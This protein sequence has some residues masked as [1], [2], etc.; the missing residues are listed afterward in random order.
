MQHSP[1]GVTGAACVVEHDECTEIRLSAKAEL[2]TSLFSTVL[3]LPG[4]LEKGVCESL[5]EAAD[6][7]APSSISQTGTA[8]TSADGT[9]VRVPLANLHNTTAAAAMQKLLHEHILPFFE[10]RPELSE[11]LF[12]LSRGLGAM[13]TTWGNGEPAV[14]R[15]LPG[16]E[17]PEHVDHETLTVLTQLSP[18]GSFTGGGT[19]FWP[20][21]E[22]DANTRGFR[23]PVRTE[24]NQTIVNLPRGEVLLFN[25]E[26]SH[27]G[28]PIQSGVRHVLVGSFNLKLSAAEIDPDEFEA[29]ER[30]AEEQ[31]AAAE[32]EEKLRPASEDPTCNV[33]R[34]R[35]WSWSQLLERQTGRLGHWQSWRSTRRPQAVTLSVS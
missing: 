24:E 22:N 34:A 7:S 26:L 3:V 2:N 25:G 9:R 18:D 29:V 8:G 1:P 12:G 13:R 15:Y 11:S 10:R 35:A 17:F 33:R 5:I 31:A 27:A 4:A 21:E 32:H 30:A 20:E 28:L 14:N 23:P 6:L 19:V 16:G